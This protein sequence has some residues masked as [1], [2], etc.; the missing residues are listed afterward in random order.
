MSRFTPARSARRARQTV[1]DA[2][3]ADPVLLG[4]PV[5]REHKVERLRPGEHLPTLAVAPP[6]LPLPR[7]STSGTSASVPAA[8]AVACER[9]LDGGE[10]TA[11]TKSAVETDHA[12]QPP[13]LAHAAVLRAQETLGLPPS[14]RRAPARVIFATLDTLCPPAGTEPLVRVGQRADAGETV[15]A[16]PS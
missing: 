6:N 12:P 4:H 1:S 9:H 8:T 11:M 16:E 7:V 2:T 3:V 5:T 14:P 10:E 13:H 15:L